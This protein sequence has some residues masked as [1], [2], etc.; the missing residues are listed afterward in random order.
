MLKL[1]GEFEGSGMTQREFSTS[2][3]IGF[4]KFGYWYRKFKKG[5]SGGVEVPGFLKVDGSFGETDRAGLELEYPN[6]VKL[7]LVPADLSLVSGL[8]RLF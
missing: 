8:I 7:R 2:K 1:V 6:G 5:E 3:G 4:H